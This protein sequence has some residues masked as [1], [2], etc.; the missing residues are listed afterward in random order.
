MPGTYSIAAVA[1][2]TGLSIETLRAWERRH[3][4][5]A[6]ARDET[7][8]RRYTDA[9]VVHL[10]LLHS[11]IGLGHPI[12]RIA[13]LSD[14][15]LRQL[16]APQAA[17]A[18]QSAGA[19]IVQKVLQSIRHYDV[20]RA[21]E[22]LAAAALLQ[23]PEDLAINVLSPLMREVGRLWERRNFSIAQEHLVSVL[24]RNLIGSMMRLRPSAGSD[25]MMFATPP[26][27][28]HEFG[29][30]LAAFLAASRGIDCCV[31]G[32]NVPLQEVARAA[33]YVRP[34][35][36]VIGAVL[37]EQ[38]PKVW[39]YI[40]GLKNR[41]TNRTELWLGGEIAANLDEQPG[42]IVLVSTLKQFAERVARATQ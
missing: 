39:D 26:D 37:H 33:H 12:R 31:L 38:T 28:P 9:D 42:G 36:I 30:C 32:P 6:P 19:P 2:I 14:D 4:V 21:E 25:P 35:T 40:R 3:S 17:D 27:E 24:V 11:A 8:I 10:Q 20:R 18:P 41:L 16:L 29:I 7:G 1:K 22:L 23:T 15:Q 13:T 34:S 5:V